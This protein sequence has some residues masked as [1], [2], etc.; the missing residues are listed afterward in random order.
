MQRPSNT[1]VNGQ[2]NVPLSSSKVN[3]VNTS[4]VV[5]VNRNFNQ[6]PVYVNNPPVVLNNGPVFANNQTVVRNSSAF[7]NSQPINTPVFVNNN[8]QIVRTS[9]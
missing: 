9:L 5:T 6:P 4:N 1:Y 8:Q 2:S 3:T 7:I